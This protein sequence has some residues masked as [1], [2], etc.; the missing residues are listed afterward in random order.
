MTKKR[1]IKFYREQRMMKDWRQNTWRRR[2]DPPRHFARTRKTIFSEKKL[3]GVTPRP[4]EIREEKGG[5]S[6]RSIEASSENNFRIGDT[7]ET[8]MSRI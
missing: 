7:Q 6:M 1:V 3:D 4:E 8:Y 5:G 2:L